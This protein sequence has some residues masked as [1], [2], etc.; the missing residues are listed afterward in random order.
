MPS[1]DGIVSGFDTTALIEGLATAYSVPLQFMEGDLED[2]KATLE[3]VSGLSNRLEDL[4]EAIGKLQGDDGLVAYTASSSN[5]SAF[6]A[7]ASAGAAPGSYT[8][9]VQS[10]ASNETEVSQGFADKDA[11]DLGSGTFSVTYGG[12]TTDV[13]LTAGVDNSL[14]GLADA[15]NKV[16]GISAYVID[17]RD[18]A[19]PYKLV[20]Q[21][22]D[23]GADN[24]I[25]LD[26]SGLTGGTLTP[27]FTEQVSAADAHV[28]VNNVDVYSASNKMTTIPGVTLDLKSSGEGPTK[29]DVGLDQEAMKANVQAFVDAYNDIQSY[30]DANTSY[31]AD[32]GIAGALVGD[33]TARRVMETLG[34]QLSSSVDTGD[35]NPFTALS[36]IG[37]STNRD[38]TLSLDEDKLAAVLESDLENVRSMFSAET[39]AIGTLK[40][41]ID[42]VFVDP[43]NGTLS[44]RKDSLNESIEELEVRIERQQVRLEDYT[45]F[46]RE[47]FTAM[48]VAMSQFEGTAA[49]LAGMFSSNNSKS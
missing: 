46:L 45:A 39:G 48:E 43:D 15:L 20:I 7:S 19:S 22:D 23:T 36:Q 31:D 34:R 24:T 35:G 4:S 29:L 25:T 40:T 49:Y 30:Y 28:V 9:D 18:G 3:K 5:E 8:I 17:T 10:L 37:I 2:E 16:D 12:V 6:T 47:K 33:S 27:T 42:D 21:G 38:G 26:A 32:E 1:V 13:T 41:T 11:F 44:S 14:Q